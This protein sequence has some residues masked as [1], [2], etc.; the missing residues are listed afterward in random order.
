MCGSSSDGGQRCATHG[1]PRYERTPRS[2]PDWLDVA[3]DYASTP[4]GHAH[5]TREAHEARE[6]GDA[7]TAALL[8]VALLRGETLREADAEASR[9][10]QAGRSRSLSRDEIDH[11]R[12]E[13]GVATEQVTRDHAISHVLGALS[14]MGAADDLIF[15]GGTALSRTYL[16][17]LRLSEDIDLIARGD[18]AGLAD[19]IQRTVTARLRRSHGDV[20]W[21][22]D[23][24]TTKGADAA[25]LRI[26]DSIQ[27]RVQLLNADGY[28]PWPT[29]QRPLIQRYS[30]APASSLTTLTAP[31]FVANKT[32]A[33][34]DR[35]A[36]RDLY[37]LWALGEHGHI[38]AEAADL[39]RRYGQGGNPQA[40]LTEPPADDAWTAALA[41]QG[42]IRIS[43]ADALAEVQEMWRRVTGD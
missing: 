7:E 27:I 21:I 22:P 12:Q 9:L 32:S 11:V 28:P 4:E 24:A 3:R 14:G 41:H 17:T 43:A 25:V 16:P 33:W 34:A 6:I 36:P 40:W 10:R 15:F 13:F 19:Q 29:E 18:R 39:F 1:R 37:D 30:D 23:L 42:H 38:D 35:H 26:G 2:D 20:T 8:R 5:L 31:A